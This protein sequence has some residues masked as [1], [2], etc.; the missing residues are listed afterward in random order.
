MTR[1]TLVAAAVILLALVPAIRLAWLSRDGP[2]LGFLHDD[3]VYWV[4]AKSIAEGGGYRIPS[5]PGAPYQ[6]K[7]PPVFPALLSMAW[8]SHA[9]ISGQPEDG[10][11]AHLASVSNADCADEQVAGEWRVGGRHASCCARCSR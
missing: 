10:G 1:R 7:Y 8:T 11:V 2:H 6:T 9:G 5:L 4:T 3:G